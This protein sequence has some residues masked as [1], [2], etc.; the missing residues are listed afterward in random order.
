[1]GIGPG[2]LL[3]ASFAA[4]FAEAGSVNDGSA[5]PLVCHTDAYPPYVIANG[6][7]LA[8]SDL[9]ILREAGRRL[10]KPI[11]FRLMP[12]KRLEID[13]RYA[14]Q[15]K[16][17]CAF[18]FSHTPER[19]AYMVFTSVPLHVTLYTLFVRDSPSS[20]RTF[21]EFA[22]QHMVIGV[23]RGF[24]LPEPIVTGVKTGHY[25]LV[26]ENNDAGNLRLLNA[27]VVDAVLSNAKIS[28]YV[29]QQ[30]G[31]NDIR[32]LDGA[33]FPLPTYLILNKAKP[34]ARL[35]PEIDRVLKQMQ[36]DGTLQSIQNKYP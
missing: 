29:K 2:V 22:A 13:L 25:R 3:L 7:A 20:P 19:T 12:W 35:A 32:P 1:M 33:S 9:E 21:A 15:S 14:A 27:G 34:A 16:I 28:T 31:P 6:A 11:E 26:E 10:G 36:G 18:S 4:A 24:R 5:P 23:R 30:A 17:E 8:G